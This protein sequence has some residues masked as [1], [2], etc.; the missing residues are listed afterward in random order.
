[1][2][3]LEDLSSIPETHVKVDAES[4]LYRIVLF[5]YIYITAHGNFLIPKVIYA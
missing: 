4:G 1:M 5:G 2:P 3:K